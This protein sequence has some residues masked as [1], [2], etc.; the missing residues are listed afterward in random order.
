[1]SAQLKFKYMEDVLDVKRVIS[2]QSCEVDNARFQEAMRI[3]TRAAQMVE[4]L[5]YNCDS[6]TWINGREMPY[7]P[8]R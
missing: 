8:H 6:W 7:A 2:L 3:L 4:K 5:G 1:M